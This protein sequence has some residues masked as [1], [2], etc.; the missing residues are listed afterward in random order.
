LKGWYFG[1]GNSNFLETDFDEL[2]NRPI[3]NDL[4]MGGNN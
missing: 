2:M 4:D 3:T 1:T